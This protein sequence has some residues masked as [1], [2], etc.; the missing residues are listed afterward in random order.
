MSK[1]ISTKTFGFSITLLTL[2]FCLLTSKVTFA[3]SKNNITVSP[4]L[5]QLDLSKDPAEAE[6]TYTNN[7]NQTIELTLTM[8]DVKELEDRGIPGILDPNESRDYNFGLSNW[9]RFSNNNLVIAPGESKTVK[10]FIDRKR[11][12]LGGHYGTVLAEL[13]QKDEQKTVKLRAILST[14]LFVRAGSEYEQERAN[15]VQISNNSGLFSFPTTVTFR[16]QNTGNVDLTPYGTV[17]ITSPLGDEVARGIVNEDSLITLPDSTRRYIVKINKYADVVLPGIYKTTVK[18]KYGKNRFNL[19][20]SSYFFILGELNKYVVIG[21]VSIALLT[22]SA[23]IL[24][25]KRKK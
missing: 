23:F 10:V 11:L 15:I 6:Y 14:L 19:T 2:A 18:L 16:L 1:L 8:Q 5:I 3:Q 24:R 4:Q 9:A 21:T 25:R 12:T 17:T 13:Q 7:T 20:D 22:A